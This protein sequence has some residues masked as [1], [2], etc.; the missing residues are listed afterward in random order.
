MNIDTDIDTEHFLDF[1]D[2][3]G[4]NTYYEKFINTVNFNDDQRAEAEE[5]MR[6]Q[7][8]YH[9]ENTYKL[10]GATGPMVPGDKTSNHYL[11]SNKV[12]VYEKSRRTLNDMYESFD[13]NMIHGLTLEYLQ[14]LKT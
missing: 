14:T 3:K 13:Q 2:S 11:T 8:E 9:P 1:L 10:F 5:F 12:Y 7:A 6:L 4:H